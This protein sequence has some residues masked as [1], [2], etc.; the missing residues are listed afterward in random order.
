M[1]RNEKLI[2]ELTEINGILAKGEVIRVA[3]VDKGEPYLVPMSYGVNDGMIYLHCAK[4]GRK[5]NVL[6][7]NP[8]VC[9]EVA[10]DKSLF[11]N[12]Q[13]CG[14]TYHFRSVIGKG[15]V[16]FV[17]DPAEKLVGLNAI[18][19][20]YGS[21]ENSFPDKAVDKTLVLR[22]DIEEITGKQSPSV[23]KL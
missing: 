21:I 19:E 6:R 1:R 13:S 9:F 15:K 8:N 23:N 5:I 7:A 10:V 18:M 4:E 22:I 20:Q 12:E 3:M 2:S 17:E 14:W 16:V 11:K